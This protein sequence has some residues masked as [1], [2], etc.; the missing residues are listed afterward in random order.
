MY[1]PPA[2]RLADHAAALEVMREHPFALLIAATGADAVEIAHLPILV[3][4]DGET[5]ALRRVEVFQQDRTDCAM[6]R[7]GERVTLPK[8]KA[9]QQAEGITRLKVPQE[10]LPIRGLG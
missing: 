9:D 1:I 3:D 4:A 7:E 2:F 8:T 10:E 5:L 6:L